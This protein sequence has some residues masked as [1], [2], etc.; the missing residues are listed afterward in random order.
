MNLVSMN[1][2][3]GRPKTLFMWMMSQDSEASCTAQAVWVNF[4]QIL[5]R[6]AFDRPLTFWVEPP[7][8][9]TNVGLPVGI[10]HHI[11]SELLKTFCKICNEKLCAAVE[12][13]RYLDE[14]RRNQGDPHGIPSKKKTLICYRF[15]CK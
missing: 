14:R 8:L 2:E 13:R 10:N 11:V 6:F 12:S 4:F 1:R 7:D 9:D 5:A 3:C 15:P